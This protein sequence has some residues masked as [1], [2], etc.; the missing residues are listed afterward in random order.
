LNS[1]QE[2]LT[3]IQTD[4]NGD[5]VEVELLPTEGKKGLIAMVYLNRPDA[6]NAISWDMVKALGKVLRR[7][8]DDPRIR[9]VLITGRG[10]GFSAGGDLKAYL[11]LQRDADAFPRFMDDLMGTFGLI[12]SMS[13]PVVALV[14]GVTVAGGIE[15]MLACDFAYAAQSARIGDGHLNYGQMGG[16]GAL[17]LLPRALGPS[18]ARELVF[19]AE[20]LD[21]ETACDWGLVNRVFPDDELIDAGLEFARGVIQRSPR[22]VAS[23]KYVMN[24]GISE[25]TGL[26]AA[27]RLERERTALY[28]LTHPDSH[29][30][31]AAFAEKRKPNFEEPAGTD[32]ENGSRP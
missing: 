17:S 9:V 30:G 23:A 5:V 20:L 22:A 16:G 31:L 12:R 18:R 15:L 6:L 3:P 4:L 14:N 11:D 19:S 21:A 1:N 2:I 29:E 28:C 10:R 13:A 32:S 7:V 24:T 25:G 26:H 27:M 8:E